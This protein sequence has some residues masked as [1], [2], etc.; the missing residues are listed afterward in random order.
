[1]SYPGRI[2]PLSGARN[3]PGL[4]RLAREKEIE[5]G[6]PRSIRSVPVDRETNYFFLA[7]V[8]RLRF[9][10]AFLAGA[11]LAAAFF[12]AAFFFAALRLAGAFLAAAFFG[13]ALRLAGA[14]F[15]AA[16]FFAAMGYPFL[17]ITAVLCCLGSH[18][19]AC[20]PR[21][22]RRIAVGRHGATT[23]SMVIRLTFHGWNST[24]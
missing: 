21:V 12:G 24:I 23:R 7:A 18:G 20:A 5:R 6:F 9:A 1:M 19:E 13:A 17:M 8:R 2:G 22:I 14:F 4:E 3:P 11:F 15:A 10:G 16:F